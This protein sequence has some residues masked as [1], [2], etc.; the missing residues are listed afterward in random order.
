LLQSRTEPDA[1][2]AATKGFARSVSTLRKVS[3]ATIAHISD[4][5]LSSDD[6]RTNFRSLKEA[7]LALD[8][9]PLAI[10]ASG[11]FLDHPDDGLMPAAARKFNAILGRPA[12]YSLAD[13]R[14]QLKELCQK[15]GENCRLIVVPGNHDYRQFGLTAWRNSSAEF[16]KSFPDWRDSVML[17]NEV[18]PV[19]V[20][21]LDSNTNDARINVARGCVG[22]E[23]FLRLRQEIEK[24]RV[25]NA[26]AFTKAFKIVVLH[27][28]PLP[29]ADAEE[30]GY[31]GTDRFLG[32]DDAG[33]FMREI[34]TQEIDLVLHGHKHYTFN[35]RIEVTAGSILR[36]VT[37]VAAGS[38]SKPGHENSF[39]LI[40]I[41]SR[42]VEAELWVRTKGVSFFARPA[43]SILDYDRF[44]DW[45]Y[46]L[47]QNDKETKYISERTVFSYSVLEYGDSDVSCERR[48]MRS[49][50]HSNLEAI[51]VRKECSHGTFADYQLRKTSDHMVDIDFGP[52]LNNADGLVTGITTFK[53][54]VGPET[55]VSFEETYRLYNAFALTQEQ[56]RRMGG[57]DAP[58]NVMVKFANPVGEFVLN[59]HFA[60]EI[61]LPSDIRLIIYS[62]ERSSPDLDELRRWGQHLR[63]SKLTRTATL[64][65][66]K[67]LRGLT[68]GMEWDL[69]PES[70][71]PLPVAIQGRCDEIRRKLLE[72]ITRELLRTIFA[73]EHARLAQEYVTPPDRV[74]LGLMVYDPNLGCLRFVAGVMENAF[75]DYRLFEG[76]GIAGRAH[77]LKCALV[78][79]R[80]NIKPRMDFSAAPPRGVKRPEILICVPLRYPVSQTTANPGEVI[81]VITLGTDYQASDL[82]K[83]DE[84]DDRKNAIT[85][86]FQ[87]LFLKRILPALGFERWL[88]TPTK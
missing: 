2:Y 38:G 32:L 9:K 80:R 76:Q 28:H 58:E 35:A 72:P 6:A 31:W 5:H 41:G 47:F 3:K 50:Q 87:I 23:E 43:F 11:D 4:L 81:A 49:G 20:F 45:A 52:D 59:I 62:G 65:V 67:P 26:D 68:Y 71:N 78:Y 83:I 39:N 85:L 75:W 57:V 74:H 82:L 37:I 16:E 46:R 7:I 36:D 77:K 88:D 84:N 60:K 63:V 33:I 29:I 79:V 48:G 69:P 15:C 25:K 53:P 18:R 64:A 44:R 1:R 54:P 8:P 22:K 24:L 70:P 73:E 19:A 27:H 55:A 42:S 86:E 51:P 17:L 13:V 14:E 21:C 66:S 34:A 40:T 56:R 10:I 12:P 61:E 30:S